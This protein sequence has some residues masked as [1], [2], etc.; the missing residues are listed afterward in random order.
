VAVSARTVSSD[1]IRRGTHRPATRSTRT[2]AL[3]TPWSGSRMQ[4]PAPVPVTFSDL[5]ATRSDD[6]ATGARS[7][8]TPWHDATL[9]RQVARPVSF[10]SLAAPVVS[11]PRPEPLTIRSAFVPRPRTR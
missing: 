10:S 4:P 5:A 8:E 9:R 11:S 1:A 2:D 7:L 6:S 3:A